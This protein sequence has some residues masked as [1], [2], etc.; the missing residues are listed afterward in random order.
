MDSRRTRD[1]STPWENPA[2]EPELRA[3]SELLDRLGA[4]EGSGAGLESRVFAA[5][6]GLLDAGVADGAAAADALAAGERAGAGP[7]FEE[8][9]FVATRSLIGQR[10]AYESGA[11]VHVASAGRLWPMVRATMRAAAA[12]AVIGA[13]VVAFTMLRPA[14]ETGEE[15]IV[16]GPAA[17]SEVQIAQRRLDEMD[18]ETVLAAY[19]SA[20]LVDGMED[21]SRELESLSQQVRSD[22]FQLG[23]IA[24]EEAL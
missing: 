19:S 22:W 7:A 17:E 10:A 21:L 12:V 1:N 15:E 13:G 14:G 5:T 16:T 18:L 11:E 4:A 8:R 23:Q 9:I 20:T 2:L 3:V 24:D 6:R